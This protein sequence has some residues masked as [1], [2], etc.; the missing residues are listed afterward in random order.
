[1]PEEVLFSKILKLRSIK[2]IL[3]GNFKQAALT[4]TEILKKGG[5]IYVL[6]FQRLL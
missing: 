1:V 2:E 6:R 3:K 5:N 4:L